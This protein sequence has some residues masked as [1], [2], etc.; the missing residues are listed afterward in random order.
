MIEK[1]ILKILKEMKKE[2]LSEKEI[3]KRI[4]KEFKGKIKGKIFKL[5]DPESLTFF[6]LQ[7]YLSFY[8]QLNLKKE[9]LS[10]KKAIE[11]LEDKSLPLEEKKK[12]IVFLASLRKKEAFNYL[13]QFKK[14]ASG[15]LKVFSTLAFEECASF[16]NKGRIFRGTLDDLL[17][18]KEQEEALKDLFPFEFCNRKCERCPYKLRCFHFQ[19]ETNLKIS[20]SKKKKK[21]RPLLEVEA[22]YSELLQ[23]IYKKRN[24]IKVKILK[25]ENEKEIE[26]IEREIEKDPLFREFEKASQRA[27]LIF[28]KLIEISIIENKLKNI[29]KELKE[30]LHFWMLLSNKIKKVIFDFHFQKE[31]LKKDEKSI[32]LLIGVANFLK[33]LSLYLIFN[34]RIERKISPHLLIEFSIL[35]TQLKNFAENLEKRFPESKKYLDKIFIN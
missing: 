35:K 10:F 7:D 4:L 3:E 18:Y 5:K 17:S 32:G 16:F 2:R 30:M 1:I 28:L 15:I 19:E 6:I 24:L 11:S 20:L 23:L 8:Q 34:Q 12:A 26:K 9:N 22:R 31:F 21:K 13:N 25:D 27:R 14:R 33:N 29:E